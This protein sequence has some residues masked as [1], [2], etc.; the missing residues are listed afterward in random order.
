MFN[1]ELGHSPYHLMSENCYFLHYV[2]SECPLKG[3]LPHFQ[4]PRTSLEIN[5]ICIYRNI[6]GAAIRFG[7][8]IVTIPCY[9][10]AAALGDITTDNKIRRFDIQTKLGR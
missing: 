5:Q 2:I 8:K 3:A 10:Y 9:V 6:W 1:F 7:G 4:A